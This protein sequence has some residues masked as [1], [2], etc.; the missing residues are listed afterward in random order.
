MAQKNWTPKHAEAL[1]RSLNETNTDAAA[2]TA[3]LLL[4]KAHMANLLGA[5]NK[6]FYNETIRYASGVKALKSL[7]YSDSQILEL[8]GSDRAAETPASADTREASIP[9]PVNTPLA[10][11]LTT[12]LTTQA[13]ST[14]RFEASTPPAASTPSE[15]SVTSNPTSAPSYSRY[16]LALLVLGGIGFGAYQS[17]LPAKPA[18]ASANS[19]AEPTA[20]ANPA[21]SEPATAAAAANTNPP[22]NLPEAA[23][24][25]AETVPQP[26]PATPQA[27]ASVPDESNTICDFSQATTAQEAVTSVPNAPKGYVHFAATENDTLLCVKDNKGV[28]SK[29]RLQA[30]NSRSIYGEEPLTVNFSKEHKPTVYYQRNKI[31]LRPETVRATFQ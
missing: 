16:A 13:E 2:L 26:A 4:G 15:S 28:I 1:R 30:K 24:K 29:V 5:D 25:P 3:S 27:A 23:T 12:P 11:P 31:Y 22:Q 19:M 9:T 6:A 17:M 21:A 10:T 20:P 8:S 7:G 18:A 14:P